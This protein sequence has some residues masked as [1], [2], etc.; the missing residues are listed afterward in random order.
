MG[1]GLGGYQTRGI[2][3]CLDYGHFY[4]LFNRCEYCGRFF[5]HIENFITHAKA[6]HRAPEKM[7]VKINSFK[8]GRFSCKRKY[9][10]ID[11]KNK[12][13]LFH[14]LESQKKEIAKNQTAFTEYIVSL[15]PFYT[16]KFLYFMFFLFYTF[17]CNII[18]AFP[19][20][21]YNIRGGFVFRW[22]Y[23]RTTKYHQIWNACK[24]Q[25]T[26]LLNTQDTLNRLTQQES[27][28]LSSL[29]C[30][31]QETTLLPL[32]F[33]VCMHVHLLFKFMHAVT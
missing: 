9:S 25:S 17:F 5:Q 19:V 27:L 22:Y 31:Y 24:Y 6:S 26:L 12:N 11:V 15:L 10:Q 29:K 8:P 16:F 14:Q 30:L 1:E 20:D 4:S 7:F 32:M 23:W 33:S 21:T 2:Q 3:K 18:L 28:S 13:K